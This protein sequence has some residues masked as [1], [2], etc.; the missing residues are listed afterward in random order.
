MTPVTTGR[1]DG[2]P[3]R[4]AG[5]GMLALALVVVLGNLGAWLARTLGGPALV[6]S[7]AGLLCALAL[8][9]YL[10]RRAAVRSLSA[11]DESG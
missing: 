11:A 1:Q 10:L 9:G 7:V 8:S 4:A 2:W 6:G 3:R 5:L